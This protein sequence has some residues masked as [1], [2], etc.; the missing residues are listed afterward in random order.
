M[1]CF[2][3]WGRVLGK[4]Q[5]SPPSKPQL[6]CYNYFVGKISFP[7]PA[8]LQK[9]FQ[10]PL[11]SF[12]F[13]RLKR[14]RQYCFSL[15]AWQFTPCGHLALQA[16][17]WD[18]EP[19]S[20]PLVSSCGAKGCNCFWGCLAGQAFSLV[21]PKETLPVSAWMYKYIYCLLPC[22]SGKAFSKLRDSGNFHYFSQRSSHSLGLQTHILCCFDVI[23]SKYFAT[24]RQCRVTEVLQ[25]WAS[26]F[27]PS[28]V[29]NSSITH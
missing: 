3:T 25:A 28:P 26:G 15:A 4:Q 17:A 10:I 9:R 21:E 18:N 11:W 13:G 20:P 12:D 29:N 22:F 27:Q 16:C 14:P 7:F 19:H 6:F 23:S 2:F 24:E 8:P 5:K 1:S